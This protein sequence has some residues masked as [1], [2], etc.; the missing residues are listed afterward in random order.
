MAELLAEVQRGV[1]EVIRHAEGGVVKPGAVERAGRVAPPAPCHLPPALPAPIR[2]WRPPRRYGRQRPPASITRMVTTRRPSRTAPE[3]S[4][5]AGAR[6]SPTRAA[7]T[8]TARASDP[9]AASGDRG[10]RSV[11]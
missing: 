10:R 9:L 6:D 3:T 1:S 2:A 7:A 5:P 11:P 8:P 4:T